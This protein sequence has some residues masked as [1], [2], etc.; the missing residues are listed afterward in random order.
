MNV[1]KEAKTTKIQILKK[2][3]QCEGSIYHWKLGIV[4][5]SLFIATTLSG[6]L[7]LPRHFCGVPLIV[8][9]HILGLFYAASFCGHD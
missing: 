8:S 6:F 5:L 7:F 9:F 2:C 4:C 3:N 1:A